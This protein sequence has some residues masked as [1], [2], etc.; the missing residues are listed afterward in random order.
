[1][2]TY[3]GKREGSA[4]LVTVDGEP[5]NPR[6][7]LKRHSPSGFEWSYG[8]SG[9]A[10]LA[11]AILADH[12]ENDGLAEEFHQRFKWAIVANLPHSGWIL[13]SD[14]IDKVLPGLVAV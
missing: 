7:D 6:F 4:I 13:T 14:E 1:M 10:Q 3:E 8:G 5:L 2:K 12:L 9:P 11:L